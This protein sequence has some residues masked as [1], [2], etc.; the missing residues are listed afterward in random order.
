MAPKLKPAKEYIPPTGWSYHS[1]HDDRSLELHCKIAYKISQDPS[2]LEKVRE[3][4]KHRQVI[5]DPERVPLALQEWEQILTLLQVQNYTSGY[6]GP[7]EGGESAYT[8][9]DAQFVLTLT[10]TALAHALPD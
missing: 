7:S 10:A 2:L 1:L 3:N 8:R 9:N 4:L 5:C 6:H